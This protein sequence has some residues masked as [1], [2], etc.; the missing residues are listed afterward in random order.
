MIL[1]QYVEQTA[2]AELIIYTVLQSAPPTASPRGS[3]PAAAGTED[4]GPSSLPDV[5]DLP[6]APA[7][8]VEPRFFLTEAQLMELWF[9]LGILRGV[10]DA[11]AESGKPGETMKDAVDELEILLRSLN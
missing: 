6:D 3:L 11:S 2:F 5:Q 4:L 8:R 9:I 7:R 10:L 1:Y